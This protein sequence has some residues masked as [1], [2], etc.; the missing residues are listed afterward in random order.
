MKGADIFWDI[1]NMMLEWFLNCK[2]FL[3]ESIWLESNFFVE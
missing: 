1:M 3:N 2:N